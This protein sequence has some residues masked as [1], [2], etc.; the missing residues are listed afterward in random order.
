LHAAINVARVAAVVPV[1]R[2]QPLV[3]TRQPVHAVTANKIAQQALFVEVR[4]K[5]NINYIYYYS[6]FVRLRDLHR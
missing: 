2:V 4:L 3:Q 6:L 1:T 5:I